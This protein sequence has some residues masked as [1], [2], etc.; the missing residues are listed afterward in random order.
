MCL[1]EKVSILLFHHLDLSS[2]LSFHFFSVISFAAQKL[3]SL[4]R[5]HL[6]IFVSIILGGGSK[7]I[8]VIYVKECS[9]VFLS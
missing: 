7:M 9:S 8:A 4:L 1:W 2:M 5:S 3:L 6:Y